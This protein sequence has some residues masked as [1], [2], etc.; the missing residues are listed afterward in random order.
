M[1]RV[2]AMETAS[3]LPAS[4]SHQTKTISS[5]VIG[6][7]S[8]EKERVEV[9]NVDAEP[10][11]DFQREEGKA[12]YKGVMEDKRTCIKFYSDKDRLA[13]QVAKAEEPPLF[14]TFTTQQAPTPGLDMLRNLRG[15]KWEVTPITTL[16]YAQINTQNAVLDHQSVTDPGELVKS[17]KG[18][19]D[20]TTDMFILADQVARR[21]FQN[22]LSNL[23]YC[24][25]DTAQAMISS[26]SRSS[27]QSSETRYTNLLLAVRAFLWSPCQYIALTIYLKAGY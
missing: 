14:K 3:R 6:V 15:K 26:L 10:A 24:S 22:A 19:L 7:I 2:T 11:V 1:N 4:I 27:P 20:S 8:K 12:E 25:T 21:Y 5:T 9:T 13:K 17:I 23:P 18:D 16:T